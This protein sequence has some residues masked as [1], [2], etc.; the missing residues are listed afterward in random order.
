MANL[1]ELDIGGTEFANSTLHI[2][3][4]A[5]LTVA[6]TSTFTGGITEKVGTATATGTT[7]TVDL[8]T[9]N[10]FIAD[11]EGV[12]GNV[13]TLTISNI[14]ATSNQ[15]SNFV[16]KIIQ[17]TSTTTRAITWASV[18]TNGTNIDWAGGDGPDITT[19]ADKVDILSFTSY[20]NG[21]TWY[22]AIVGQEFS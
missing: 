18:V 21:T 8:A 12:S 19:G 20:D 14:S 5:S 4:A 2:T 15:V 9:G 1:V 6:G 7:I 17:G 11:L 16:L 3:G 22:G 10:F 13:V